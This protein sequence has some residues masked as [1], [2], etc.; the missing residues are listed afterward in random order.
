MQHKGQGCIA[1]QGGEAMGINVISQLSVFKTMTLISINCH[2]K[3]QSLLSSCSQWIEKAIHYA[4]RSAKSQNAQVSR[5]G[6]LIV[7]QGH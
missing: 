5:L 2:K 6:A 4:S 3:W 1:A 7:S